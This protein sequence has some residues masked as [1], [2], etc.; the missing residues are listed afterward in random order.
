MISTGPKLF[1][2]KKMRKGLTS[3][4]SDKKKKKLLVALNNIMQTRVGNTRRSLC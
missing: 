2:R 4:L 1:N 3:D